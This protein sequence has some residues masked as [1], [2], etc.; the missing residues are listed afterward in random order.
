MLTEEVDEAG[1]LRRPQGS[2]RRC[3]AAPALVVGGV[4][5]ELCDDDADGGDDGDGRRAAQARDF[6]KR[7]KLRGG[8]ASEVQSRGRA[9]AAMAAE[10]ITASGDGLET[11]MTRAREC[12]FRSARDTCIGSTTASAMIAVHSQSHICAL[13]AMKMSDLPAV[14]K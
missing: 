7:R 2:L 14:S 1:F 3:I 13:G 11:V 8:E 5:K 6:D 4:H 9:E 10:C 12:I